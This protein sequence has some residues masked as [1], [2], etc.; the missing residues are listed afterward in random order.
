[1]LNRKGEGAGEVLAKEET[2][3][4][5]WPTLRFA[6]AFSSLFTIL[7]IDEALISRTS[8]AHP[9]RGLTISRT[10][11]KSKLTPLR[12]NCSFD[13]PPARRRS[14]R[15]SPVTLDSSQPS[16]ALPDPR[17]AIPARNELRFIMLN[18]VSALPA[19]L[20][21]AIIA[22]GSCVR[23]RGRAV[24]IG[25]SRGDDTSAREKES[26]YTAGAS[27]WR[28]RGERYKSAS[29]RAGS[30]ASRR[31]IVRIVISY[32]A[33]RCFNADRIAASQRHV[34]LPLPLVASPWG[35]SPKPLTLV[36][37]NKNRRRR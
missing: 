21:L 26:V 17:L 30:V 9:N 10:T 24:S 5:I 13:R 16:P 22:G 23:A 33:A 15:S 35:L 12:R 18:P 27:C 37:V 4:R 8:R 3:M 25:R 20:Q 7:P 1:M 32:N 2:E 19:L 6:F 34:R 28:V 36:G 29:A 11:S 31:I 14:H